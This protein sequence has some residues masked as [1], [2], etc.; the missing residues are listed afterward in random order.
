MSAL[1]RLDHCTVSVTVLSTFTVPALPPEICTVYV[2]AVVGVITAC[3]VLL[4]PSVRQ[5]ADAAKTRKQSHER[6]NAVSRLRRTNVTSRPA[7]QIT[8][9]SS[10]GASPLMPATVWPVVDIVSTEVAEPPTGSFSVGFEREHVGG[11]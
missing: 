2:V 5:Q 4:H 6:L 8:K 3:G 7:K 1:L 10:P 9:V 11:D